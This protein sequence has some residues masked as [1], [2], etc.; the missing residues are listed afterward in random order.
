MAATEGQHGNMNVFTTNIAQGID[1]AKKYLF[2]VVIDFDGP[3]ATMLKERI[4]QDDFIFRAKSV[5]IPQKEFSEMTTEY[6]GTKL[7]YP[8]KVN[9]SGD[10]TINFDEFQDTWVS[11]AFHTWQQFITNTGFR[12]DIIW[13]DGNAP[14]TG[15]SISNFANHYCATINIVLYDSTLK[16][17]LP[18]QWRL[19]RCWPKTVS[20]VD[21]GM[22]DD[23]KIQRSVTFSYSHWEVISTGGEEG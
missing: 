15:G 1:L 12:D 19:Y 4:N 14:L 20:S 2:Q 7:I 8:G 5:T 21:L 9:I 10:V 6:M 11:T 17:K 18:V 13:N 16:K 22:E 23:G 3:L